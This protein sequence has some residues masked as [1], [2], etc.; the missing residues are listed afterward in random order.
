M[1]PLALVYPFRKVSSKLLL[2]KSDISLSTLEYVIS[3][4]FSAYSLVGSMM[5]LGDLF[6]R[7]R[8]Y[9]MRIAFMGITL[10][11]DKYDNFYSIDYF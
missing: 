4:M 3:A 2:I 6:N 5:L 8:K 11:S 7:I 9:A 10:R 1:T